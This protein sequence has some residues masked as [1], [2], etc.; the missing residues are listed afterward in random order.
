MSAR[1]HHQQHIGASKSE[2]ALLGTFSELKTE[3]SLSGSRI[4]TYRCFIATVVRGFA[5]LCQQDKAT[6][7]TAVAQPQLEGFLCSMDAWDN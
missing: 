4:T 5:R 6:L 7:A 1:S 3:N 2:H